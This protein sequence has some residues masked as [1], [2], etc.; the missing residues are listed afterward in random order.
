MCQLVSKLILT[1]KEYNMKNILYI[2]MFGCFLLT[3]GCEIEEIPNP[4]GPS[5]EGVLLDATK[6]QLQT[7]V[8]GSED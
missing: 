7:L 3:V 1:T 4:N 6:S 2:M 5:I 8:T